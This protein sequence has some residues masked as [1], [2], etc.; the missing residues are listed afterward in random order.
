MNT[1]E[2]DDLYAKLYDKLNKEGQEQL[3]KLL[4]IIRKEFIIKI[5]RWLNIP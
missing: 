3:D 5:K 2:Y 4:D 1:I